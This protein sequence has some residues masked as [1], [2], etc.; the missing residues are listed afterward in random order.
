MHALQT[1]LWPK[2]TF[3]TS[4]CVLTI[5]EDDDDD[6]D[7]DDENLWQHAIIALNA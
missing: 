3:L 1:W 6:D 7:D 5:N 4:T 2:N